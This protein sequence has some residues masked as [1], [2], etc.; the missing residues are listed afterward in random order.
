MCTSGSQTANFTQW[1]L[2]TVSKALTRPWPSA[3][4]TSSV[5]QKKKMPKPG[6]DVAQTVTVNPFRV[7]NT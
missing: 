4:L 5:L 6:E 3:E 2:L 7:H 1:M